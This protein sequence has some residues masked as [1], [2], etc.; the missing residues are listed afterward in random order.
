MEILNAILQGIIQGVT[1]FLPVSSSGHLAIYQHFFG[2]EA[3]SGAMFSVMLHLGTLFAV[4]LVYRKTIG[5]LILEFCRMIGDIFKGKFTFKNMNIERRT[6][7]MMILSSAMLLTMFIPVGN[8]QSIKDCIEKVA[9]QQNYPHLLWI[10]GV[11]LLLTAALM[12]VAHRVTSN[13]DRKARNCATVKDSIIIGLSQALAVFPGLSRSGTTT[14]TALSLGLDK[15]YATQYSFVLSIPAVAAAALLEF[16][17]ALEV[18]GFGSINW[19]PTI[20]GIVVAALVGIAAIKTFIWLIKK[21][22]YIIF[23]YYCAVVG[24]IIIA[25]SIFENIIK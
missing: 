9:D 23:S 16:K 2:S 24:A 18:E 1:E 12:F 6:I 8:G 5:A 11:M 4:C 10:I 20:I 13:K 19:L 7:F 21:N 14:A 3:T 25:I 17:D 22:R 15:N